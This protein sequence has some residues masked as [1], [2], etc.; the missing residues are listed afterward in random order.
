ML[1]PLPQCHTLILLQ[2]QTGT[3]CNWCDMDPDA[4]HGKTDKVTFNVNSGRENTAQFRIK[5]MSV[6]DCWIEKSVELRPDRENSRGKTSEPEG[7]WTS[8]AGK[9][10]KFCS[11]Q[12][13][14]K[15]SFELFNSLAVGKLLSGG[16]SPT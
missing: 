2:Y 7:K 6:K 10:A 11:G 8:T 16:K 12:V 4:E 13:S 1:T 15:K 9:L 3:S 5:T 14:I